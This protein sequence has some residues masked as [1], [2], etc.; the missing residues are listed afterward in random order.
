MCLQVRE[1]VGA[2]IGAGAAI[3]ADLEA[4]D[5]DA[6][7]AAGRRV[8]DLI[9]AEDAVA[10]DVLNAELAFGPAGGGCRFVLHENCAALRRMENPNVRSVL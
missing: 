4:A 10:A 5:A 1:G 2:E 7:L 8:G 3:V 6:I 9:I